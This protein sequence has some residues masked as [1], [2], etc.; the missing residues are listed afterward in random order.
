MNAYMK[1]KEKSK[2][3]WKKIFFLQWNHLEFPYHI[4]NHLE[5]DK[6]D[7]NHF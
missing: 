7:N 1:A 3:K 5:K 4:P 6:K 2:K